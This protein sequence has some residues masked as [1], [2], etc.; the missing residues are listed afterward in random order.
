MTNKS[1]KKIIFVVIILSLFLST[2]AFSFSF[3]YTKVRGQKPTTTESARL[4]LSLNVNRITSDK[5]IGL[6]PLKDNELQDALKGSSKG[7]CV[8]N[9]DNGRCQVYEVNLKNTGNVT[10]N[11]YSTLNLVPDK[12]SKFT[13]LKWMEI[14]SINDATPFGGI[15]SYNESNWKN[16]YVMGANASAKFYLMIWISETGKIQN[17]EDKGGFTGNLTFNSTAGVGTSAIFQG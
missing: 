2:L 11:V 10:S 4:G 7:M 15:H 1:I 13:N 3:F 12:N 5:T 9:L 16:N 6:M 17:D 14:T 8:D